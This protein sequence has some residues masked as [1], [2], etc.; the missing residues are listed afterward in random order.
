MQI[1]ELARLTGCAVDTIRYYENSPLLPPARSA[2]G[3]SAITPTAT[4]SGCALIRHCR[5]LDMSLDEIRSLLAVHDQPQADCSAVNALLTR[6][7]AMCARGCANCRRWKARWSACGNAAPAPG[8]A[9]QWHFARADPHA[10]A[11]P[12]WAKAAAA[13]CTAS[14]WAL[15]CD[16]AVF[17]YCLRSTPMP[18][19]FAGFV[20][21]LAR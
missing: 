14:G 18:D 15:W 5:A 8:A 16:L 2:R 10:G 21:A 4:S 17:V 1:G 19:R 7:W 13:M 11:C 9:A 20:S 12:Q 6:T 3:I